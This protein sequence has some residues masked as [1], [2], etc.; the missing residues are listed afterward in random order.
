[1]REAVHTQ[2]RRSVEASRVDDD[3]GTWEPLTQRAA[4]HRAGSDPLKKNGMPQDESVEP[5]DRM[6]RRPV[7]R[8]GPSAGKGRAWVQARVHEQ[9]WA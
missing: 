6:W 2:H 1:M 8:S 7:E 3:V 9:M 4:I 5:V